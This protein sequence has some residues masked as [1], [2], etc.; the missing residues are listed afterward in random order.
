MFK[1]GKNAENIDVIFELVQPSEAY[2]H[3]VRGLLN[4]YLD[5][6][7]GE[8][9]DISGL[10]DMIVNCVSIGSIVASSLDQNPEDMPEYKDLPDAEFEKVALKFNGTRDVYGFTTILS[11]TKRQKQNKFFQ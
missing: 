1:P 9:L 4:Q 6:E 7:E 11:V 10:S 2:F 5:G 3:A 8:A